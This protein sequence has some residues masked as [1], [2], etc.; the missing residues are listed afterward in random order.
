MSKY[1]DLKMYLGVMDGRAIVDAATVRELIDQHDLR[2]MAL[3]DAAHEI[4]ALTEERD[5][6][7]EAI[8]RLVDLQNS[9]RGPIRSFKLWNDAVNQARP[10]LGLEVRHV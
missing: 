2:G 4:R 9:G 3:D 6:M 1:D 7:R 5:Q 10:L 8:M